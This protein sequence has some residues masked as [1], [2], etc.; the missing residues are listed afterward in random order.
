MTPANQTFANTVFVISPIGEKG[1]ETYRL[2]REVLDYVI[3]PAVAAAQSSLT[4]IRADDI[5]RAGSFIRDILQHLFA[6]HIVIADLTGQ[7]PNV[8]YE[9]GV[10]HSISPRTILI[11]Q[12]LQ[13]IPSDLREYRTIIYETNAKGVAE[14]S[15]RLAEYLADIHANPQR[16]DNPVLD[17]LQD[18]VGSHLSQ[19][20]AENG[21]LRAQMEA[22]LRQGQAAFEKKKQQSRAA[23]MSVRLA[24]V[25][26]ILDAAEESIIPRLDVATDEGLVHIRVP[27]REGSFAAHIIQREE[28]DDLFY[29]SGPHD[30]VD[31][32]K[33]LADARV[34]MELCAREGPIVCTFVIVVAGDFSKERG[35]VLDNFGK[36]RAFAT[37]DHKA[38]FFLEIWD[39]PTLSQKELDLGI[40][41]P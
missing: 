34:L 35:T 31:F 21:Q 26:K 22:L 9:L 23:G 6:S 10:R 41:L 16:P 1:S 7:N 25:L 29:I 40:K 28:A 17:R 20:E 32:V 5:N 2:F 24:R 13:D 38:Q 14:F 18:I 3:A 12:S 11:A 37:G 36:I 39:D 8:F 30:Y 19:L 33:E 27:G 15:E 4:V